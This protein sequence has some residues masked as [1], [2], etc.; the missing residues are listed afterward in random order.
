M[1]NSTQHTPQRLR[2]VL[3]YASTLALVATFTV[4]PAL[5]RVEV[6]DQ[7]RVLVSSTQSQSNFIAQESNRTT[8]VLASLLSLLALTGLCL[9]ARK[10]S[11]FRVVQ[12]AHALCLRLKGQQ[13]TYGLPMK[14]GP[15]L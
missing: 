2:L 10:A 11:M 15:S 9:V 3:A 13:V 5:S 1:N 8:S 12:N 4:L 14:R 6:M 7:L